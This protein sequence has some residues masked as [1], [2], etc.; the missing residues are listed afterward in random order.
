MISK[1]ELEKLLLDIENSRVERT[2]ST[3]NTDKFGEAICA[4]C[5]DFPDSQQA[6]YLII[7]AKDNGSRNGLKVT[8]QLQINIAAIRSE[9]NIQPQ[10]AMAIE[11][12]TFPDGELLVAEVQPSNFPPVRY[13][14]KIWIRVGARKAVA[15]EAEEKILYEKRAANI[16]TFD[17]MPCTGA[18]I[19]DLDVKLFKTEYLPKAFPEDILLEDKRDI[20]LKLQSLGFFDLRYDCPTYAGIIMF[21][22]K[23]EKFLAGC[24]VQYVRFAGEDRA[25]EILNEHKFDGN[26]V[27]ALQKMDTFVEVSIAKEK[28]IP[29]SALREM[30]VISYP[31]YATRELLMNAIMHRDY[32]SNAPTRFY[33]FDSYIEIQNAGGLYGKAR[34]ENFPEVNDYR[35]PII[36]E[37]MKVLGYVNRYNRGIVRVQKE[38]EENGNGKATFDL[39]LVTAFKVVEPISARANTHS[40]ELTEKQL[41]ILELCSSPKSSDEIFGFI[42][43]TNQTKNFKNHIQPLLDIQFLTYTK[44]DKANVKGQQYTLTAF[45][46]EWLRVQ[47]EE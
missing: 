13:K 7:G 10:P 24:Y 4:F 36:A 45:G 40:V 18:T 9:G 8:D 22:I 38:L 17:A 44:P 37:A 43:I 27:K 3:T 20:K 34:P 28:P 16:K 29:V 23:P 25:G 12:F 42:G 32:E 15:N 5:N 1:E 35:N 14:G 46:K 6:G 30:K 19:D 47:N 41:S 31:Y 33:E 11:K 39:N 2:I 26:L 21:G